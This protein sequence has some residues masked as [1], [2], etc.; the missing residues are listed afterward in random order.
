MPRS[1]MAKYKPVHKQTLKMQNDV[2]LHKI[3]NTQF[4]KFPGA[5][6]VKDLALPQLWCRSDPW[7]RIFHMPLVQLNE[8][9]HKKKA[10][11]KPNTELKEKQNK[12]KPTLIQAD[13]FPRQNE[14]VIDTL[15]F[16]G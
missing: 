11:K 3:K 2:K 10:P 6:R 16:L 8:S 4:R 15:L 9:K 14:L 12:T 5:Q 7:P 13:P 1:R